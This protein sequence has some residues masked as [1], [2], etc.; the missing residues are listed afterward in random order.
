M[1]ALGHSSTASAL[2]PLED[3]KRIMVGIA[4]KRLTGPSRTNA[5]DEISPRLK[6]ARLYPYRAVEGQPSAPGSKIGLPPSR[7][8]KPSPPQS[9]TNRLLRN[10][11]STLDLELTV[12]C[13][14]WS[15]GTSKAFWLSAKRRV[16]HQPR[17]T[18]MVKSSGQHSTRLDARARLP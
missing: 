1:R 10:S 4:T 2:L 14:Q 12:L 5:P 8:T 7:P 9:A 3:A 13:Q 15:P 6:S 17:L 16:A 18:W 11:L